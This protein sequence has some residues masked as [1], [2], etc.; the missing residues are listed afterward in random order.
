MVS[1]ADL[2]QEEGWFNEKLAQR[3]L[4]ALKRNNIPGHYTTG[5]SEACSQILGMIP[6]GASIGIGDSATLHQLGIIEELEKRGN[7]Q[8]LSPFGREGKDYM[9][10]RTKEMV[11]RG[12]EALATSFFLTGI[13]AITLDGKIVNTDGVGNRVAGLL[14]GPKKVIA[15]AGVNKIVADVEEAR[16]RIKRV[17]AP[18]NAYRHQIKHGLESPPCAFTGVCTDCHQPQ[19]N[20]CYTVI[21]E[22]QRH[23]RIEVILVGERLGL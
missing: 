19:R 16:E 21:V 8:I 23:P 7:C 22:F 6:P 3:C 12:M 11:E 2:Q 9:P 15:V 1:E 13:N 20:C 17:A 10:S 4:D 18:M 14:F 5:K